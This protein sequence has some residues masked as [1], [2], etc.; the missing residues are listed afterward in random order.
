MSNRQPEPAAPE[1]TWVFSYGSLMSEPVLEAVLGRV[2]AWTPGRVAGYARGPLCG[3]CYPGA[4]PRAGAELPGRA[5]QG[6]RPAELARLDRFEGDEYEPAVEAVR[7]DTGEVVRARLWRLHDQSGLLDGDW[8]FDEFVKVNEG[9]YIQ[10]CRDWATQD[11]R[12]QAE[13]RN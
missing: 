12:E 13:L 4:V 6:V 2:P 11:D 9:W 7:L 3:R 5:L 8:S 1:P 10:M